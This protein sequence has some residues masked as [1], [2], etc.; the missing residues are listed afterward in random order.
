MRKLILILALALVSCK[1]EEPQPELCMCRTS[2]FVRVIP[3]DWNEIEQGVPV[4]KSCD[5]D[6]EVQEA[7]SVFN[8][9]V[10]KT[11]YYEIRI[12]CE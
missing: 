10:Q 11:F 7:W 1:K 2:K 12:V 3:Q 4:G 9:T 6:G 8:S 5:R